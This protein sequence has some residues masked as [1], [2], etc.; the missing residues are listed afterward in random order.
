VTGSVL[1]LHHTKGVVPP[2]AIRVDR[3]S[4]WG[5]PFVMK[6]RSLAERE[7]VIAQY[8]THLWE[9]I[10]MGRIRLEEL[11]ALHGK[12][13]CCWCSPALCH[14][15]VLVEAAKWATEQLAEAPGSR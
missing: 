9:Q 14:S 3:K 13:L 7:R 15:Q 8:R 10:K 2:G 4:A 6:D 1:N 12:N 11:A 5:N